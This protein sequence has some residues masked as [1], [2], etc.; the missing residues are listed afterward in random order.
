MLTVT[1]TAAVAYTMGSSAVNVRS[2]IAQ[3]VV[4]TSPRDDQP[5]R[6]LSP[7]YAQHQESG[8]RQLNIRPVF[9]VGSMAVSILDSESFY[10]FL[11]ICSQKRGQAGSFQSLSV[12]A[13]RQYQFF[14]LLSALLRHI[15][16][17]RHRSPM[18]QHVEWP[19][20]STA[21]MLHGTWVLP[22]NGDCVPL[23]FQQEAMVLAS[24]RE[25]WLSLF[26]LCR[27]CCNSVWSVMNTPMASF[28]GRVSI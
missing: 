22:S 19:P 6:P 4:L 7:T 23:R 16:F 2:G 25:C 21:V 3:H 11:P 28:Q 1:G 5:L 27:R 20:A 15:P 13:V 12:H 8:F 10:S 24:S 26:R 14:L 18:G 17:V 9:L